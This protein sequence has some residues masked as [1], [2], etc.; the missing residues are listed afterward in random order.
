MKKPC[1]REIVVMWIG[2]WCGTNWEWAEKERSKDGKERVNYVRHGGSRTVGNAGSW[3][4][5]DYHASL[6]ACE[7]SVWT[8]AGLLGVFPWRGSN[9]YG[10]KRNKWVELQS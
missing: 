4:V 3:C 2:K 7:G 8:S 9:T 6:G 5:T 1:D 10:P